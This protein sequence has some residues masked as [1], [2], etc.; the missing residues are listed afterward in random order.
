[1]SVCPFT[2]ADTNVGAATATGKG[3]VIEDGIFIL[4]T[5]FGGADAL[6]SAAFAKYFLTFLLISASVGVRPSF[7]VS[8]LIALAWKSDER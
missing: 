4:N 2:Q 7:F 1:M 5:S 8:F 3:R 6:S